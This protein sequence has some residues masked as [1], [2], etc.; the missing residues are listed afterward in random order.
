MREDELVAAI[1]RI[2]GD[3]P[4]VVVGIGDDAAVVRPGAGELVLTTD[5][6]V[7]GVHFDAASVG[8]RDLGAKALAV[9]VSDVAAMGA[10]PRWATLGLVTRRDVDPG[11]LVE[12]A[13]GM[14]DASD[15]Y[16]L[17]LVGGDLSR[18]DE[19]VLS[20]TVAG[21]V[22][23]GRAVLRSGAR[24]GDRILVTG[25]L[26]APG[27]GLLLERAGDPALLGN[28][29]ARALL[30]AHLRP[31]ARVTEGLTLAGAGASAMM[32]VSDGLLLDLSRLCSA[33]DVG[34]VLN[35]NAVP[36]SGDLEPLVEAVG[37]DARDLALA[38]GEDYELLATLR[39]D[40]VAGVLATFTERFGL[41][42]TDIGE[43]VEG[44]GIHDMDGLPLEPAGWDHF[45]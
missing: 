40:A 17:S 38:G 19:V 45:A 3:G 23:P 4:D 32:D 24:A 22:A 10:S 41:R 13:G 1:R 25:Q 6:L 7:E 42:L 18:G 20:V 12:L 33:S 30:R 5:V 37:V 44:S 15:E 2:T 11:W 39:S 21:E 43:I 8:A 26:G 29:W 14:K 36:V 34:A 31:V 9:N 16:A 35:L 27:G 28:D